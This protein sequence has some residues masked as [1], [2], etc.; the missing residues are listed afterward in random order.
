ME[1]I[2]TQLMLFGKVVLAAILGGIIGYERELKDKPAGLR[3]HMLV[4]AASCAIMLVG[5]HVLIGLHD[6]EQIMA[7]PIRIIQAIILGIGFIGGGVVKTEGGEIKNLTTAA[8]VLFVAIV[9]LSVALDQYIVA[10]LLTALSLFINS[11]LIWLE[12]RI[13]EE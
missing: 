4:S 2:V 11:T 5:T 12:K 8:S 1:G 7:D 9:G 10:V 13:H 3:T 6:S